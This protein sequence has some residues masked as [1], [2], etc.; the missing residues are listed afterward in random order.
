MTATEAYR[1]YVTLAAADQKERDRRA[2]ERL[3]ERH[4]ELRPAS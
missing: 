4:P 1:R 2:W 3:Y